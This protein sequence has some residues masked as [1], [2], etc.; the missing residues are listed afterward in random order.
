MN[1]IK[2]M[3]VDDEEM[4][5]QSLEHFIGQIDSL[6]LVKSCTNAKDA[7]KYLEKES[8]D[9]M[10]LDVE[11]PE[12]TGLE[13]LDA[14]K[15]FPQVILITSKVEYAAE[16]FEYDVVDYIV[17]PIDF[18]RFNKAVDKVRERINAQLV[19]SNALESVFVK[20]DKRIYKINTE[21]ILWVEAL[22]DYINIVTQEKKFTVHST[23]K[24]FETKLPSN[25]FMRIHRSYI[26]NLN[27]IKVIEDT[28]VV[29]VDKVIP[30]GQSYRKSLMERLNII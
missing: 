26:I 10:F 19:E 22:G 23:M 29:I 1:K 25:S 8:V 14:I 30:I 4:S 5:R 2:C 6:E 24:A 28:I 7:M 20:T 15:Q 11:M 12:M 21:D 3:L 9:L 27:R 17:K 13:L 18:D 16:A